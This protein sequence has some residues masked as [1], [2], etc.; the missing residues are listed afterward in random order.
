MSWY[1]NK[2]VKERKFRVGDLVVREITL[3]SKNPRD[4]KLGPS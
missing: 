1:Y 2:K 4:G 3:V